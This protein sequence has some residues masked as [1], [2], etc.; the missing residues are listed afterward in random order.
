MEPAQLLAVLLTVLLFTACRKDDPPTTPPP[1][2]KKNGIAIKLNAQYFSADKIDSAILLWQIN[3]KTQTEKLRLS[4]DTLLTDGAA[5]DKG[6]GTLTVQIFSGVV[7]RQRK[8]QWERRV[9][10]RLKQDEQINW[11]AP[12]DYDDTDWFPRVIMIDEPSQFTAIIALRPADT[13]FLLKNIPSGFKIEL[14]RNYTVIPGGAQI[15]G[16]G[17]WKCNADCRDEFGKIENRTYFRP[18]A[19]HMQGKKFGMVEVGVGLFG[20][21]YSAGPGF[22]FNHY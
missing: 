3:G 21:N 11:N 6:A 2:E 17:L 16:G 22:Y 18:L 15:V 12:A 1:V 13:Y 10:L 19:E 5:L 14:E 7:L 20:D 4:H 9:D 8:L